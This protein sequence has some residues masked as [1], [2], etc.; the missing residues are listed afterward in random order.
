M[1]RD[2]IVAHEHT[3]VLGYNLA[4]VWRGTFVGQNALALV[5]FLTLSAE[6]K[7]KETRGTRHMKF[8]P[9]NKGHYICKGLGS[10]GSGEKGGEFI[11]LSIQKYSK[12]AML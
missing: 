9:L 5:Q 3:I 8:F 4:A 1:A 2:A 11:Y 12:I 7:T 10:C 6:S